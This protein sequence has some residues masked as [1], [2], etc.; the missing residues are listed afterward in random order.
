[1]DWAAHAAPVT[2]LL[3]IDRFSRHIIPVFRVSTPAMRNALVP[4]LAL[5]LFVMGIAASH[6]Q[7][8]RHHLHFGFNPVIS[9]DSGHQLGEFDM[10]ITPIAYI[11][12]MS[13]AMDFRMSP[14]VS[15]GIRRDQEIVSAYGLEVAAPWYPLYRETDD[16]G[17]FLVY[18]A[19]VAQVVRSQSSGYSNL[20]FW[21]EPGFQL[22]LIEG[23][24]FSIGAQAGASY[25]LYDGEPSKLKPHF[26]LRFT[27]GVWW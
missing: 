3:P 25:F 2:D 23:T 12:R 11:Y 1:M 24:A 26:G 6:A 16:F 9:F 8:S 20:A 22:A 10:N 5:A 19:P 7:E 15:F 17:A 4:T 21:V 14:I 27:W 13:D 18:V